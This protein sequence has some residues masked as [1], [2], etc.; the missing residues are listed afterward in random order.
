[1]KPLSIVIGLVVLV[2]GFTYFRSS[3]RDPGVL[4]LSGIVS[5]NEVIVAAKIDG[6]ITRLHVDEGSRVDQNDLIADLGRE[7]IEPERQRQQA[8]VQQ[9]EAKLIQSREQ[10][11]LDRDRARAQLAGA[12]AQLQLAQSQRAE[13]QAELGQLQRDFERSSGLVKEG[14]LAPQEAEKVETSLRVAEARIRSL[15]DRVRVAQ[16]DLEL[17]RANERQVAVTVQEVE[18][19]SAQRDQAKAQLTQTTARLGYTEVRAPLSGIVSLRVARQGEVIRQGDPI[20]TIVDLDDVWVRA[21]VEESYMNRVLVGQVLPVRLASGEELQGRVTFIAPET[22]FATQ[23][24]VSRTKRDIRTFGIKV[25]LAN[26]E[27]RVHS[28]MTAYV[29]L[30]ATAPAPVAQSAREEKAPPPFVPPPSSPAPA[31]APT[32][33]PAAVAVPIPPRPAATPVAVGPAVVRVPPPPPAALSAASSSVSVPTLPV[34]RAGPGAALSAPA[35]ARPARRSPSET[36]MT[37]IGMPPAPPSTL[38]RPP[39]PALPVAV[40]ATAR[41]SRN[42]MDLP[43][44]SLEAISVINGTPVAVINKQKL[45]AGETISGARVIRILDYQVELEYQGRRFAIGL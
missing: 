38:P 8:A 6:R 41:S 11:H 7:E 19:I 15:D 25:A 2:G 17:A 45:V 35:T 13:S 27:H 43:R 42:E 22:E 28:G 30:P 32:A 18:Q 1:M 12:Q 26:P 36:P 20:V 31:A 33:R 24:D 14:L 9:Q 40:P 5:A 44:L 29:M 4:R 39:V 16:A 10:L 23:R 34:T 3:F 21:E 37:S